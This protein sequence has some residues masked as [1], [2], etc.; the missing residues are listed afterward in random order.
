MSL[1]EIKS[2]IE[3][4]VGRTPTDAEV[5]AIAFYYNGGGQSLDQVIEGVFGC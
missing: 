3:N 4:R 2:E 1:K 5:K